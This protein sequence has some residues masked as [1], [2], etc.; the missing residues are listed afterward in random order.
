MTEDTVNQ[1]A[2]YQPRM[3]AYGDGRVSLNVSAIESVWI[4]TN[5]SDDKHTQGGPQTRTINVTMISGCTYKLATYPKGN[6]D[7]DAADQWAKDEKAKIMA[8]LNAFL[9]SNAG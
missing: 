5:R 4:E 7:A 9:S 1:R 8:D 6:T 3:W 2:A